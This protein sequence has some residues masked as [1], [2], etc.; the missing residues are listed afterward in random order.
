V[1]TSDPYSAIVHRAWAADLDNATLYALL[2]L[3]IDVFVVE[4][5][6]AYPELDGRDLEPRARHYWLVARDEDETLLGCV[7]LLKESDT[8]YRIGR[9]CTSS[10]VRGHKLGRQLMDAV[11]A[12]V[13]DCECVLDAQEQLVDFYRDYGFTVEGRPFDDHGIEHVRMRRAR[14]VQSAGP[15]I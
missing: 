5:S 8:V 11:L 3:R 4:Q 15:C 10:A 14:R 12:E 7:R 9:L 13:G 1:V 2:K 6:C